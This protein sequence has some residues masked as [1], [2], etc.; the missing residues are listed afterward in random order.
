MILSKSDQSRVEVGSSRLLGI[1]G[2][3]TYL[4]IPVIRQEQFN[5][6][7]VIVWHEFR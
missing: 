1:V 2:Q 3:P 5:L 4:P 7:V 6:V